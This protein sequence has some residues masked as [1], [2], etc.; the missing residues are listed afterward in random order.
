MTNHTRRFEMVEGAS[1]KFWQISIEGSSFTVTYGRIGTAGT[2]KTTAC[3]FPAA[4]VLVLWLR[5]QR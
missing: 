5:G 2:S 4:M 1:S 3:T